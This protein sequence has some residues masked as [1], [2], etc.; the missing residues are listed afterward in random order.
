MGLG[1]DPPLPSVQAL[2]L[3]QSCIAL[4]HTV[5]VVVS[6]CVSGPVTY[7]KHLIVAVTHGGLLCATGNQTE[8]L[9]PGRQLFYH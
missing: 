2:G 8:D 9:A 6:S 4:L 7:G 3:A 1:G 5:T